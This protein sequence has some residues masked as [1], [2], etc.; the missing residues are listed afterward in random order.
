MVK[1][2]Q[3]LVDAETMRASESEIAALATNVMM[4][5]TYWL[6]WQRIVASRAAP[7]TGLANGRLADA[8]FQ[9]MSLIA[10]YLEGDARALIERLR[11]D[12]LR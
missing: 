11:T 2:S 10:P 5:A 9:V 7:D 12:Y 6:S 3:G 8:A 4:I 1:L